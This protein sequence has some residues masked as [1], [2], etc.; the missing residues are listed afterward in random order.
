MRGVA[1][2]CIVGAALAGCSSGKN[3]AAQVAE[4]GERISCALAG[5]GEF[6]QDCSVDRS[7]VDGKLTL[8]VRH[9]DGSFRRFTVVSDGRGVVVADGADQAKAVVQGDKLAVAVADDRYLFPA[10]VKAKAADAG[11]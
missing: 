7:Q 2:L 5:A 10:T 3:Q 9:P 11:K 8:V 6:T 1:V 4:G